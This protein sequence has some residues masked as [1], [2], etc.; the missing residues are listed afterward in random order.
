MGTSSE[1]ARA[2]EW[3]ITWLSSDV[4][5]AAGR[6]VSSAQQAGWDTSFPSQQF[7]CS[8][9]SHSASPPASPTPAISLVEAT[10][11][12]THWS[13]TL[14]R[15]P[16]SASTMCE[17]SARSVCACHSRSASKAETGKSDGVWFHGCSG[18]S[19]P[20]MRFRSPT[21][22]ASLQ[23]PPC[24]TISR[25]PMAYSRVPIAPIARHA[26][27]AMISRLR[28]STVPPNRTSVDGARLSTA[29]TALG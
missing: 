26:S 7:A 17:C 9:C 22:S 4:L 20:S 10:S 6:P 2:S 16:E 1:L 15:L 24:R 5:P 29:W 11:I 12:A 25:C 8:E 14:S 3:M 21:T 19:S 28:C 13:I 23:P 27:A 18:M